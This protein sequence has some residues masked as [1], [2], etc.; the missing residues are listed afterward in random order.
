[1]DEL[2]GSGKC[3]GADGLVSYYAERITSAPSHVLTIHAEAEGMAWAEWF[4]RLLG[5]L[6]GKG[7][8]FIRLR[9]I[10]DAA[11][12]DQARVSRCELRMVELPGRAGTVALQMP[13]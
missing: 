2:L 11:L 8:T 4:D 13:I 12:A 6:A 10:A 7:V 5:E 3:R 9:E 1:L